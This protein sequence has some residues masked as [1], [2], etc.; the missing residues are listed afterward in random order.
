MLT[1]KIPRNVN[2][3]IE[4]YTFISEVS[5][6]T[7][8][9]KS[10]LITIDFVENIW[11]DATFCSA[12]G[13][14]IE[15]LKLRNNVVQIIN[16][17]PDVKRVF[18]IN[19]FSQL[20]EKTATEYISYSSPIYY[21]KFGVT[22]GNDFQKYIDNQLL[23]Y[24]SFPSMSKEVRVKIIKSILEIFDNAHIHGGCGYVYTCGQ[25]FPSMDILKFSISDMGVTVRK[26]VNDFFKSGSSISGKDAIEWAV[27]KGN[28][29]KSIPGG[30][31]ISLI[32][33]FLKLNEGAI[34]IL[35]SNGFWR[36]TRGVVDSR[37]IAPRFLGTVV[38][39]EFNLNDK[40]TYI[41]KSEINPNNLF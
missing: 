20:I 41:L 2:T 11:F 7:F 31:G 13:A 15:D 32:R 27:E 9:I 21:R 17:E 4:G 10:S 14:L 5:L 33:E 19:G 12:L 40:K 37:N 39:F 25:Y 1:F 22:D 26:K 36:E 16:V 8:N 6:K 38:T 30:L 29:T 3:D 28:T 23:G 34:H 35:S 24:G 18:D